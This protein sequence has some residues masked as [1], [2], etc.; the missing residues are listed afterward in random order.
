MCRIIVAALFFCLP[1][2]FVLP[3]SAESIT[4]K[5]TG[6]FGQV[7]IDESPAADECYPLTWQTKSTT[8]GGKVVRKEIEFDSVCSNYFEGSIPYRNCRRQAVEF[9]QDNCKDLKEKYKK[10]KS[11][12]NEQFRLD[13]ECFCGAG[14]LF[15]P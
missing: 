7:V 4:C 1:F 6:V 11:P 12:Y 15:R 9:F 8:R 14:R 10:T 2:L 13:M 5:R 3:F